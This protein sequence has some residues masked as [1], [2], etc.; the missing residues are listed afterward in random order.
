M[1]KRTVFD[2][3]GNPAQDDRHVKRQRVADSTERNNAPRPATEEVTSARQ[4]QAALVFEQGT[5][6]GFRHGLDSFKRFLDSI[7]YSTDADDLPRKRSILRDYLET[8]KKGREE[9][10]T[11]L[12][13]FFQAWDYGAQTSSDVLISKV[14]A[15]LALLLKVISAN[16]DLLAYG[17]LLCKSALQQSVVRRLNRTLSAPPSKENLISPVLRLLTEVTRFNEGAHAKAVYFKRDYTLEPKILGRNIALWRDAKGDAQLEKRKPSIRVNAVRYLLAHLAHQDEI[18]KKEILANANVIRALFDHLHADPSFLVHEI[19]SSLKSHVFEDRTIPRHTKSRIL[20]GKTLSSISSLYR[21]QPREDAAAENQRAPDKAAHEFL[22]MVCTDPAYGIMLPS[23]GFYPPSNDEDDVG[24]TVEDAVDPSFEFG[25][26]PLEGLETGNAIRNIIL[27]EFVQTLKP[28]ANIMQQ[29]LLVAIFNACP[30]LVPDYFLQKDTFQYD[31]KLSST[32]I[33]YSSF[34][35]TVIELPVPK[36]FGALNGFRD[37]PPAAA[38]VMQSILPAPLTQQA[39]VKCL[40]SSSDMVN[41]VAVR[42]L[43]VAFHK[44]RSVMNVYN[45]NCTSRSSRLWRNGAKRL[46]DAFCS[47]CPPM[48]TVMTTFRQ[49][50][51]LKN[52]MREAIVR[53]LR[54]YYEVTPQLALEEKFDVSIPLC[55]AL[56]DAE[57]SRTAAEDKA[58]RVM[59]LGHWVQIARYSPTMRWWQKS[60]TL[61]HSPFV[62]LLRLVVCSTDKELYDGIKP[63]LLTVLRDHY[64]LQTSTSPDALD[65][66]IAS[67][68]GIC[69]APSPPPQ[70]LEFLDDCCA[71]FVR[72]PIKY[73]DDLDTLRMKSAQGDAHLST[74]SPLLMTLVEQWPFRGGKAEKG[75]PAEPLAQWLSKLLYLL[76]LIGEEE[77]LLTLVCDSLVTSADQAYK[78]VLQD[79]FLWKMGKQQAKEALKAATGADFSGSERSTTSSLPPEPDDALANHGPSIDAELPPTEDQKHVGLVKWRKKD[80]DEIVDDGDIGEL[81]LCLC[82]EHK[83]IRLQAVNNTRQLLAKVEATNDSDF[84]QLRVLLGEVLETA[85]PFI[86][87]RPLPY[88]GGVFAARAVHVLADPTHCLFAKINTFLLKGPQWTVENL[89]RYFGK[90]IVNSAPDQDGSY[91]EEVDWFLDYIIDC[92]RTPQDMEIFRTKN[93]F[94]RLLTYYVSSS[95]AISAKEKIVRLLLRMAAVGGSTTLITRCGILSWIEM[96]LANNDRRQGELMFLASRLWETCDQA[97]VTDW[98]SGMAEETIRL[99][100]KERNEE[101]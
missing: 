93:V 51:F 35:Y 24:A 65:A 61:T 73:F 95:C 92:L 86:D 48:K 50:K 49:P 77:G 98:S 37:Y 21:Y 28:Y 13:N 85:V 26:D 66:V 64:F 94:E 68:G 22:C 43:I 10:A 54:L 69:G 76:K 7:L 9:D 36:Y 25:I 1:G 8:Q 60:K 42:M 16:S 100:T 59:E 91:H 34:L 56:I 32:W 30:E 17:T 23:G 81:L 38:S 46:K 41:L 80:M 3:D 72:A 40:N 44:L 55:N 87:T 45:A 90:N 11:F 2:T 47:V 39:L 27:S 19:L 31:P 83:E 71:R 33:G 89:P 75:N 88:V 58:L 101:L 79:S 14:T 15:I 12:P 63:L 20:N 6:T 52:M 62:T 70:V 53:L 5:A 29:E 84:L 18:A 82:S 4:L 78:Q 67:L 57:N 99:L 96:R 74:I 97:K